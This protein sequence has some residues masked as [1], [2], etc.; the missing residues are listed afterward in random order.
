MGFEPTIEVNPRCRFSRPVRSTAPPPRRG[1]PKI[2]VSRPGPRLARVASV[3]DSEITA[4]ER[5][6]REYLAWRAEA[7]GASLQ[8]LPGGG[9][10]SVTRVHPDHWYANRVI[11]ASPQDCAPAVALAADPHVQ[12]L[13]MRLEIAQPWL[14]DRFRVGWTAAGVEPAWE[15]RVLA[16]PL[17][18]TSPDR[19][20]D[21]IVE[22]VLP[23]GAES[24]WAAY[25]AC[26]E[27]PQPERARHV[28]AL[29]GGSAG[30]FR[31]HR[32]HRRRGRVGCGC[33]GSG[34]WVGWPIRQAPRRGRG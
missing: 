20:G 31:L 13:A 33:R 30:V 9:A 14:D 4:V 8:R 15:A 7:I 6:H 22:R 27:E 25:E 18:A 26:F 10:A 32:A 3:P 16:S 21:A 23:D 29:A 12:A 28:Q 11:C 17:P 2:A 34:T 24:F 1:G 5:A 19:T